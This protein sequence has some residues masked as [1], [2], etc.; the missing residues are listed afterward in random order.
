MAGTE[1]TLDSS[2]HHT[3]LAPEGDEHLAEERRKHVQLNTRPEAAPRA[4]QVQELGEPT[5]GDILSSEE[6]ITRRF[7]GRNAI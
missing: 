7:P 3:A 5:G 2:D 1:Q 6:E 4:N